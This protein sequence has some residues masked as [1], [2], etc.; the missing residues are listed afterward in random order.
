MLDTIS[1]NDSDANRSDNVAATA[2]SLLRRGLPLLMVLLLLT[3]PVGGASAQ[4]VGDTYCD[5]GVEQ[6]VP[7]IYGMIV[8][9]AFP[10]FGY[11]LAKAGIQYMNAGANPERKNKA[12]ESLTSSGTGFLIVLAALIAP[13][14]LQ[15]IASELGF[16]ISGCVMPF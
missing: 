13:T 2:S 5:T 12:K 14:L 6:L 10:I 4:Q 3:V 16:T 1:T 7:I 8:A 15:D 9:L 11:S